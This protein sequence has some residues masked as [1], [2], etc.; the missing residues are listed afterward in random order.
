MLA[1]SSRVKDLLRWIELAGEALH[2]YRLIT[3]KE[4]HEQL[5]QHT[6]VPFTSVL[7]GKNGGELQLAGLV[8]TQSVLAV[9]FLC[10]PALRHE[11]DAGAFLRVCDLNGL[12]MATNMGTAVALIPWLKDPTALQMGTKEA[13][14]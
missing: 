14:A 3:T 12:P 13:Q 2:P 11:M 9:I 10:D 7:S 8:P 5:R 4:L 6:D 1:H